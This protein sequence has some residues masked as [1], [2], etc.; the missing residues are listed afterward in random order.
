MRSVRTCFS[1]LLSR[2]IR[3]FDGLGYVQGFNYLIVKMMEIYKDE[4]VS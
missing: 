1:A 2:F 4:E 3:K